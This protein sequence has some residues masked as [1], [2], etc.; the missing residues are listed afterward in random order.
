MEDLSPERRLAVAIASAAA[1]KKALDIVI[2]DVEGILSY[3]DYLVLCSGRSDRQVAA[4]ADGVARAVR[5]EDNTR[6]PLGVEGSRG[7]RWVLM[8][9]GDVVLHVFHEDARGFYDLERLWYDAVRVDP[10]TGEDFPSSP[11]AASPTG[12]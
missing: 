9:F 12:G 1:D 10:A 2:M 7:G 6:R 4:I 3:T 5:D 11:T 8:D